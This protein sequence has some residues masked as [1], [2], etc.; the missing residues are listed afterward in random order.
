MNLATKMLHT[1][2]HQ[3][4]MHNAQQACED[5]LAVRDRLRPTGGAEYI[6]ALEACL[7]VKGAWLHTVRNYLK[8]VE[9]K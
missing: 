6:E 8:F 2:H 7:E 4:E 1:L 5:A 9:G 3:N